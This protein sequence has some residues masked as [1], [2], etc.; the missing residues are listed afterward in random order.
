ML[1][2]GLQSEGADI[3]IASVASLQYTDAQQRE[4][5]ACTY[6]QIA[7]VDHYLGRILAT[8]ICGPCSGQ[9]EI[10]DRMRMGRLRLHWTLR[11]IC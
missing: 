1:T 11:C 3:R 10:A 8:M 4:V 5:N 9:V 2:A 6:G 7:L